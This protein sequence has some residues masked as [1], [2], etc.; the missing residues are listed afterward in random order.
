MPKET[1]LDLCI[2]DFERWVKFLFD[3]PVS[4]L[5]DDRWYWN[6]PDIV[7]SNP[8]LLLG[9]LTSLCLGFTGIA[10]RF[11]LQQIDQ[12]IW[13]LLCEPVCAGKYL[14][15]ASVPLV[16]RLECVRSMFRIYADFVAK[17]KAE[18]M[19]NCFDMWWDLVCGQFWSAVRWSR[20]DLEAFAN[21]E[22]LEAAERL[23]PKVRYAD[24]NKEERVVLDAMFE[25]LAETLKL[26]DERCEQYALHGLG[27]LHHPSVRDRV[28]GFIET[29]RDKLT[30]GG[31]AWVE[32]CRDGT[33]M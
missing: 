4:A 11:T 19:E 32:S 23:T 21:C 2:P 6:G 17:S 26:G 30:P 15:D 16:L 24:L 3:H 13:F 1:S 31:L 8:S 9:H 25:A 22:T 18:V 5:P 27:H 7:V 28:Q 14:A 20:T 29:K 10:S 33:V 12:G